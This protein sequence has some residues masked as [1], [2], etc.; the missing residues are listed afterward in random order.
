MVTL[1]LTLLEPHILKLTRITCHTATF[2]DYIFFNS[3]DYGTRSACNL[4]DHLPK[5]LIINSILII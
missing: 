2:I 3:I 4:S 1:L 5:F